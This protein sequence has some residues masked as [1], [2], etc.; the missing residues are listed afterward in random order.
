MV[1]M[2][3]TFVY[4][5]AKLVCR[6][7]CTA[8]LRFEFRLLKYLNTYAILK[9]SEFVSVREIERDRERREREIEIERDTTIF[10]I[11]S[12]HNEQIFHRFFISSIIIFSIS[13]MNSVKSSHRTR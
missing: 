9:E 12:F 5:G 10:T 3:H 8:I 11:F 13:L 6:T 1:D 4:H 7:F 2:Y